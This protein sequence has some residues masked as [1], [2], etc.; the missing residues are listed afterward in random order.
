MLEMLIDREAYLGEGISRK[1]YRSVIPG[2]VIKKS[3]SKT[4]TQEQ[5]EKELFE[6]MTIDEKEVFPIVAIEDGFCMM[7]EG[8]PFEDLT[9]PFED[10]PYYSEEIED[11]DLMTDFFH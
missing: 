7:K 5:G 9:E 6:Q 11:E 2:Y 3:K 10:V 4:R 1:V 8:V